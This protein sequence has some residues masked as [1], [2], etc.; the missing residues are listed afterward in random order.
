[1]PS[2]NIILAETVIAVGAIT[3]ARF[4]THAGAQAT[5]LGEKVLGVSST[6]AA[7]GKA[8]AIAALGVAI[9]DAGGVIAVGDDIITDANGKAVV[10]PPLGTEYIIGQARTVGAAGGQIEVLLK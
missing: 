4:V 10:D 6:D 2:E 5:I 9:V 3:Q 7:T 1:M 8:V